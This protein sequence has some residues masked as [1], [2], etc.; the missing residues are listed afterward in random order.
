MKTLLSFFT[1]PL[2][3]LQGACEFRSD[4]GMTWDD[5]PY[6]PRSEAY[7]RG[8]DLAHRITFRIYDN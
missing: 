3:F 1:H 4:C 2:C 6:S 8:R 7:D 5:N